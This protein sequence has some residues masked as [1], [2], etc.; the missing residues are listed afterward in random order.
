MP[1][2]LVKAV[3]D[4]TKDLVITQ[5]TPYERG[6][7]HCE[8]CGQRI[9]DMS[10]AVPVTFNCDTFEVFLGH[11]VETGYY[12]QRAKPVP[13]L[14]VIGNTYLGN[15]CARRIGLLPPRPTVNSKK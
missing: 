1:N 6:K 2:E 11:D 9:K 10:K 5:K 13:G 12:D 14:G 3:L 7:P 15:D 4:Y 8:R